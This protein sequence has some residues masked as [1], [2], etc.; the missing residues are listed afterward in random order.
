MHTASAPARPQALPTGSPEPAMLR[1]AAS[2]LTLF[3]RERI[4]P[5]WGLG[6][7]VVLLIIFGAVPG[8]HHDRESLGGQNLLDIYLPVLVVLALA[9]L[10]L[11]ALPS[12]LASYRERG[13]LRRMST[14]PV[15]PQRVLGAQ[16]AI[17]LAVAIMAAALVLGAGKAAY[18][19]ALPG[20]PALYVLVLLL[21]AVALLALGLLIAAIAPGTRA[22]QGIGSLIFFPLMFFAGLWMPIPT[23]PSVLRSISGWTPLGA[24]VQSFSA[25]AAGHGLDPV[26]LLVLAGYGLAFAAAAARLFRWE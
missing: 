2:E 5:V 13:I 14:T 9:L 7:P 22:A 15:G 8:F 17:H 18:G 10:G 16:L 11:N 12:I 4:G 26:R 20:Q 24:A 25:T 23:M 3:I 19:V 1:L 6:L 21:A